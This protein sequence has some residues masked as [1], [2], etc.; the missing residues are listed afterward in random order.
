MENSV[1]LANLDIQTYTRES[2]NPN[3]RSTKIQLRKFSSCS[4][5][6][7]R[8]SLVRGLSGRRRTNCIRLSPSWVLFLFGHFCNFDKTS[9]SRMTRA[10]LKIRIPRTFLGGWDAESHTNSVGLPVPV[11]NASRRS[12]VSR[13]PPPDHE[14]G[15]GCAHSTVR[16]RACPTSAGQA[17]QIEKTIWIEPATISPDIPGQTL[18]NLESE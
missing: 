16:D 9:T 13:L 11:S 18:R 6:P 2:E 3:F 14:P 4:S 17:P 12:N 8:R 1:S 5:I 7:A 10:L 15:Q